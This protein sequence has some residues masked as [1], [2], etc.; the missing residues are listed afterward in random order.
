[1]NTILSAP[2][3]L[4]IEEIK[5]KLSIKSGSK[6]ADTFMELVHKVEDIAK[7]KAIFRVSYID[8][9]GTNN[10]IVDGISFTS[11]SLRKNLDPIGRIFPY[12]ATCGIEI[13]ELS[14]SLD[15][16]LTQ[17]WLEEIKLGLLQTSLNYLRETIQSRYQIGH[18]SSMNPGSGNV[19]LWP[20]EQQKDLFLLLGGSQYIEGNVGVR[21][22]P[23]YLMVP[24]MSV[25][26]IL[27]PSETDYYNCQLCQ[28]EDC[29]G[30][31]AHFDAALWESIQNSDY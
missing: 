17:F 12:V 28:R 24:G 27:F 18:L 25:S 13:D 31:R 10:I 16:L 15:D 20:I 21:L 19:D 2:Y 30:R 5:S 26:G 22:L 23:S 14:Y 9:K 7:P 6:D 11:L 1:M 29:P 4:N 3:Q 8:E